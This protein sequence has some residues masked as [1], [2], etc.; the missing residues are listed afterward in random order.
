MT[1]MNDDDAIGNNDHQQTRAK[2]NDTD[3]TDDDNRGEAR[4]TNFRWID[5]VIMM[6][7][8]DVVG[9]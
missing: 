7:M 8:N 5:R 6:M 3:R 2:L 9:N 1:V 4:M